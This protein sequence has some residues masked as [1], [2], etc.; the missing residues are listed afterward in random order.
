[1]NKSQLTLET[2]VRRFLQLP[3]FSIGARTAGISKPY[4]ALHFSRLLA[5][6]SLRVRCGR[7]SGGR[8]GR[9]SPLDSLPPIVP[10]SPETG[11]PREEE[12]SH[13]GGRVGLPSL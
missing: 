13:S 3:Y 11:E 4:D 1:M 7:G 2:D 9:E 8:R 12:V 10:R 5:I 6:S